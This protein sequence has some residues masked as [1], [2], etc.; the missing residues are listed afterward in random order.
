[1]RPILE[2]AIQIWAPYLV[3]DISRIE[4]V[5][6]RFIRCALRNLPWSDKFSLPQYEHRLRLLDMPTLHKHRDLL[7]ISFICNILNGKIDCRNIL[8]KLSLN[9]N[10][11][12]LRSKE[13]FHIRHY[14]TNYGRF[15][16][17]NSMFL[18]YNSI[19]NKGLLLNDN[20]K[21]PESKRKFY[22]IVI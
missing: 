6:R 18:L 8:A 20:I 3:V 17:L 12:N 10:N 7:R 22:N 19:S 16:P 14:H 13:F 9:I 11:R 4:S 21:D 15:N 5:Q 2:Y 1:M